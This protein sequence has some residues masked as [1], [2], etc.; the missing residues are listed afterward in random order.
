MKN[1]WRKLLLALND[2]GARFAVRIP[3]VASA[4]KITSIDLERTKV[5]AIMPLAD[6]GAIV[7][8]Y[9]NISRRHAY[10]YKITSSGWATRV[11]ASDEAETYGKADCIDGWY[12]LPQELE[13]PIVRVEYVSGA[14]QVCEVKQPRKYATISVDGATACNHTGG[15]PSL[16][17]SRTGAD[18]QIHFHQL[19]D[20]GSSILH[21]DDEW[22]CSADCN[23]GVQSSKGW[24]LIAQSIPLVGHVCGRLLAFFCNGC[25]KVIDKGNFKKMIAQTPGKPRRGVTHDGTFFWMTDFPAELWASNGDKAKC[26]WHFPNTQN[27]NPAREGSLFSAD[28][29]VD[30]NGDLLV[31][32]SIGEMDG[33]EVWRIKT[34]I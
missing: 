4:A 16:F 10:I 15:T 7:C 30:S 8:A 3:K 1:A 24:S 28:V 12:Y 22:I 32:R 14:V 21:I 33:L 34:E 9:D 31:A 20:I 2:V 11:H 5:S 19:H 26:I 29:C 6:G 13:G 27:K 23:G 17:D 18:L 25:V